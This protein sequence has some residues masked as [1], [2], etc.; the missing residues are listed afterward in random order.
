[1][2]ILK[3]GLRFNKIIISLLLSHSFLVIT[4]IGNL[5]IIGFA[6][7]FYYIEVDINYSIHSFLDAIWWGFS[8]ATTVGYGD[9]IPETD[10]GKIIGILLMLTGTALF[11]TYTALFAQA[12]L[13]DEFLRLKIHPNEE[14]DDFLEELLKHKKLIEKQIKHYKNGQE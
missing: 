9:I 8:T 10:I 11:A 1:M 5:I 13:E 7:V 6:S 3:S 14:K 2:K 4:L 12:I